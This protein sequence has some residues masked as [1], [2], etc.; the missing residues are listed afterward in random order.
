[1]TKW[2]QRKPRRKPNSNDTI[3]ES[4]AKIRGVEDLGHWMNPPKKYENNPY[5]LENIDEAVSIITKAIYTNKKIVIMADVDADGVFACAG[6]YNY[7]NGIVDEENLT[8]VHAQRSLGHG[9]DTV[10]E[11]DGNVAGDSRVKY[12]P[13]DT[14][15]LIIVDS[16]S[17]SVEGCKKLAEKGIEIVIIDHHIIE[18]DNP[19]AVIVNCQL[20]DYPN[21][22]LS[23][24]AMVYK[25]CKVIDDYMGFESSRADHFLDLATIGLISDMMSLRENENRYLIYQGLKNL[26]NLGLKKLLLLNKVDLS[27]DISTTTISFKIAPAI[28]SCT[29]YDKMEMALELLT[30]VDEEHVTSLAKEMIKLN[31]KRKAEESTTVDSAIARV[32]NNHK[33][34]V[35]IANEI[36]SGFRG[37]VAMQLVQ[38]LNKPVLVLTEWFD[39]DNL[40][41]YTGSGRT[42]G[43]LP[44]KTMLEE[45]KHVNW[46]QGHEGAFGV[47]IDADDLNK[48]LVAIDNMIDDEDLEEI[49]YYDLEVEVSDITDM[50]IREVEKFSLISGQGFS[51]PVFKL[52]GLVVAE[53][54]T[55]KL[56]D[57][58]RAVM[59]SDKRTVKINIEDGWALMKFKSDE[60]Y[61]LD[62][63]EHYHDNFITELE[64]VG[65]L[66]LNIFFNF[67]LRKNVTTMQ[68]FLQDYKIVN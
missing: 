15:L 1:M 22:H 31:D 38:K 55:K 42:L 46:C 39:G 63:E 54:N 14:Q 3:V 23:G 53:A 7:L 64:A 45:T 20:G 37:L 19:Y 9:V 44:L 25:V 16:S 28:N 13:D 49:I 52:T 66:N 43:Q 47:E 67:G 36:D 8:Y 56:G 29:R 58:V 2:V 40:V 48:M 27:E 41:K 17:N 62:I 57:H 30:S 4:L 32:N 65:T 51:T 34:A 24:S 35:L 18:R 60:T 61:G 6:M 12:I 33:V 10:I 5:L 21:R 50:D 68:L 59:G 11:P 26:N